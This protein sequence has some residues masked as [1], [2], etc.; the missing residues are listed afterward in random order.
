MAWR[1]RIP[2]NFTRALLIGAGCL[3]LATIPSRAA[4]VVVVDFVRDVQPILAK[5]C[6]SCHGPQKQKGGLRLDVKSFALAGG[7]EAAILP[8][9]GADSPLIKNVSSS[10]PDAVMPPKGERLTAAQIDVL[11]VWIDQGAAWPE[12]ASGDLSKNW[13]SLAPVVQPAVPVVSSGSALIRNPIDAFILAKLT[14]KGLATAPE[15]KRSTLIR[16]LKLDLIGLPPTPEE[17][18]AFVEDPDP[19]AYEKLVETYLQSPHYGERW[20]R[21]WLDVA[22]FAESDGFEEDMQRPHAWT[23]RDYVIRSFN[24]DKPYNQF[25]REQIAGDAIAPVTAQ[26]IAATGFLVAGSWDAL[27]RVTPSALGRLQSREEQ[28]EE[29]VGAVCQTFIG[30]TVQCARCHNHKFDPIPQ[31]DYYRIKAVFEGVDHGLKPKTQGLRALLDEA[32]E[33]IHTQQSAPLRA[34][35]SDLEKQDGEFTKRLA[36]AAKD[37]S[38]VQ[39][40]KTEQAALRKTLADARA[41]MAT[42]FPVTM[43]FVGDRE[44]PKPTVLFTRGDITQPA[45]RVTPG[46]LAAVASP[47][48]DLGLDENAPEGLRRQRFAEWL[49]NPAHPLTARVMVNRIWQYHFGTGLVET[50]S[51]FGVNGTRPSHPELL[52]WLAAE[53]VRRGWS[54]KAMHRLILN[55]AAYRQASVP[56][57]ASAA[58]PLQNEKAAAIDADNRLLWRFPSRRIEGEIVRDMMLS[59]SGSLNLKMGG[60][61]F[62][63][64]TVTQLNTYFYHLFDKDEP[65]YNRRSIYRIHVMTARSPFLDALDC[66][67]PAIIT[68][69]RRPTTT[70]IQALALMNDSFAIRQAETL[71]RNLAAATPSVDSQVKRAF[72]IVLCRMPNAAELAASVRVAGE[73]GLKEVCWVLLNSSEFL[74]SR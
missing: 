44:T 57:V 32:D 71:A 6:F 4:D 55:S 35:I 58:F 64:Y 48:A 47:A 61:S 18:R 51:D 22:R 20:A 13:W 45:Q 70:P 67:S 69:K 11:R 33:K 30:L 5:N 43:A 26:G 46:G 42:K 19:A 34:R 16:R 73:H 38:L 36:D 37:A 41:E 63:P 28:L 54:V 1:K 2:M 12:S 49:V 24:E 29:M 50:P 17:M 21:H 74:Y 14:E 15:A 72:E 31:T 56:A 7:K 60:P 9:K 65:I 23:F 3:L 8:G 52:D 59:V 62:A 40:L 10:D 53:F 68:A 27:A 25:V 39:Q 66:P